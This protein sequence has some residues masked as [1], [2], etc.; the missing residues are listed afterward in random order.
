[1]T[2]TN[3]AVVSYRT[4]NTKCLQT[5]TDSFSSFS[6]VLAALLN[7]DGATYNVCPFCIFET[8]GLSFFT[9]LIRI[10]TMSFADSIGFF[11]VFDTVC[12]QCSKNLLFS[13]QL[14]ILVLCSFQ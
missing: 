3:L 5:D 13:V 11:D 2:D 10:E 6:S 8:D 4:R 14:H 1:M 12:V 7:G 9:S